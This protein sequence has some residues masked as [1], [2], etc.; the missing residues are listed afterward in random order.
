MLPAIA[1]YRHM[2]QLTRE[3]IV[4]V[5]KPAI[6]DDTA[7]YACTERDDD[8]ILHP[9]RSSVHVLAEGSGICI[10][11]QC[12]RQA[13]AITHHLCQGNNACPAKIGCV[14]DRACVV[15]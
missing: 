12:H 4:T 7:T 3:S 15:I 1:Y 10:I 2:A 11:G 5:N 6:G 9:T 13:E 8:K 14:L